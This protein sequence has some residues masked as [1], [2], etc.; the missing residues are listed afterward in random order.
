MCVV[1]RGEKLV[2]M[3]WI[4]QYLYRVDG[5]AFSY[6]ARSLSLSWL[7][8]SP[9]HPTSIVQVLVMVPNDAYD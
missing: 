7:S 1:D 5:I 6:R 2:I 3:L 9:P 4:D 8:F